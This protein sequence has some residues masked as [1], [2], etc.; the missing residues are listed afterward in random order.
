MVPGRQGASFPAAEAPVRRPLSFSRNV[1]A[2]KGDLRLQVLE[3]FLQHSLTQKV[4]IE[5]AGFCKLDNSFGDS[6]IDKI[7]LVANLKS[8]A[9]HFEYYA[10][11]PLGL[12]IEFAIVQKL[13][14]GHDL[15]PLS[16]M[17]LGA[18]SAGQSGD[19]LL[20]VLTASKNQSG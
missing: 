12:G 9:S 16:A 20:K 3:K 18:L 14:D 13:R 1:L 19:G 4:G 6:F 17:E 7:A 2:A 5:F 15:S 11:D 10:H 8:S